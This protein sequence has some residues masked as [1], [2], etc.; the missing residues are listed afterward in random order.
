MVCDV[1]SRIFDGG[2]G[3]TADGI[4]EEDLELLRASYEVAAESLHTRS[5]SWSSLQPT[6]RLL[7]SAILF[8]AYISYY[9]ATQRLSADSSHACWMSQCLVQ[10]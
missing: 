4:D 10:H 2:L 3:I 7:V 9:G 1:E 6:R 5:L 8:H